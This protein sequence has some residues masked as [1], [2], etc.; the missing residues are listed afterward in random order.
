MLNALIA[1]AQ[2][3]IEESRMPIAK[4]QELLGKDR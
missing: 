1:A 4:I 3:T 2:R